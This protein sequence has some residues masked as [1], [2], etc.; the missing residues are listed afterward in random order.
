[1]KFSRK[2]RGKVNFGGLW[3]SKGELRS[4]GSKLGQF[5]SQG[6]RI[7]GVRALVTGWPWV[8]GG[9]TEVATEGWWS[10]VVADG[11]SGA[12]ESWLSQLGL[13]RRLCF[14]VFFGVERKKKGKK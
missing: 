3:W 4:K 10:V 12:I 14:L 7:W 9:R 2:S 1:M 6:L 11:T 8:G 5:A 13:G